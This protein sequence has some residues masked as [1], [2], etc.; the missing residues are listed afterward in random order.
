MEKLLQEDVAGDPISG[1]RWT[2]TTTGKIARQLLGLG[3]QVSAN[4]VGRLLSKM[5]FS[6]KTNRK[7]IES[8]HKRAP[9]HRVRRTRQFGVIKR[10]RRRFERATLPIVSVDGKKR[11]LLGNFKNPGKTWRRKP[12]EVN[13]HDF[14]TDAQGVALPYGIY[15]VQRNT[16]MI[17]LG[18]SRETPAFAVDA[19]ERWW[20]SH[21]A[22]RYPHADELL[23][24]ADC[25]GANSAR[26]RVWKCDLQQKLCNRHGLRVTV[27][28]YPPGASKWN[29]IEHRL[30]SEISK[31]WQ[32]VPLESYETALNYISTTKTTAGLKVTA[33]LHE[34][35]YHTGEHVTDE[36]VDLL[37]IRTHRTLPEWTYTIAPQTPIRR[38]RM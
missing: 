37:K 27:C 28:H 36:E 1:L 29:P 5:K 20:R 21:G 24:L 33:R 10:K 19:L 3:I 38:R 23:I 7:N 25:G 6:L 26:S 11:E 35:T 14:P 2:R 9:G 17:V 34:K 18:T 31:N 8:G 30:F 16:G 4:T 32:G 15:D 13:D 12:R 22:K